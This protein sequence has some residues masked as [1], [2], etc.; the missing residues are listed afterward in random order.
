VVIIVGEKDHPHPIQDLLKCFSVLTPLKVLL[1]RVP[2]LPIRDCAG[3]SNNP[4]QM[5]PKLSA[6]DVTEKTF[7]ECL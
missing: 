5:C 7:F 1:R 6:I 3:S 4:A 2:G